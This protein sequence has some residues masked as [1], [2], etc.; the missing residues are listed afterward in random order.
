MFGVVRQSW[1]LLL[2]MLFL[3]TGNGLQGTVLGIRGGIEGFDANTMAWVMSAYFLGFLGGSRLAPWMI[4]RVGHVRV[5]AALG[6]MIS[7][8]F[9]LYAAVP[10]PWAWAV[11]RLIV[12]FCFS[13]VYV[14]AESWLNDNSSNETRGQALS[15]YMITQ[16][17]GILVAQAMINFADPAG[18]TLF[19]I[20][21]VLVSVSFAP[22]LLSVSPAPPFAMTKGMTL[23]ALFVTSPLGFVGMFF[24]GLVFAAMFGMSAVYGT[25]KGLSVIDITIFV[26]AFYVGGLVLQ[27]PVGWFS[28]RFDRRRLVLMLTVAGG[29]LTL[30]VM[31]LSQYFL[32]VVAGAFVIGGIANPLYSLLI[33]HTA[34]YLQP[35]DMAAASSGLIFINGLGAILGPFAV[36]AAMNAFGADAY[37][38]VVGILFVIIAGYALWRTTRRPAIP[39][40]DT[41]TYTAVLPTASPVAVEVATEIAIEAAEESDAEE[42]REKSDT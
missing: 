35:E 36:G 7:A 13:G 20:M 34:D 42:N 33:A 30:L 41:G 10:D 38:A 16:L 18:F 2:G 22:I 17:V 37:F 40:E 27:Y 6:S 31:P 39:V 29:V 9:I 8:A 11:M 23:K 28:D 26:S 25:E 4:Q 1:A 15:A 12:G 3:M 5:F 24:L 14:V 19:V 32:I 21:S